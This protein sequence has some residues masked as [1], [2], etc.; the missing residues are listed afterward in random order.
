LALGLAIQGK[1]YGEAGA[2]AWGAFDLDLALVG[3]DNP[4]ANGQAQSCTFLGMGGI[5]TKEAVEHQ[6]IKGGNPILI[7]ITGLWAILTFLP[8]PLFRTTKQGAEYLK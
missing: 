1:E 3:F 7:C 5:G 4:F 2:L 8:F 6:F